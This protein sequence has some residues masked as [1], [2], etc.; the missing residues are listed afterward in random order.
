M[1][2]KTKSEAPP[3][4]IDAALTPEMYEGQWFAKKKF[5]ACFDYLAVEKDT[6]LVS[7]F[8]GLN[9]KAEPKYLLLR[10]GRTVAVLTAKELQE[11]CKR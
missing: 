1:P 5:D 6:P 3:P 2:T 10:N 8:Y 9:S 7:E 11:V 4:L